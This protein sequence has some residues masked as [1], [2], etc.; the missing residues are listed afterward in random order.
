LLSLAREE[1]LENNLALPWLNDDHLLLE[2]MGGILLHVNISVLAAS[3]MS[4]AQN[5]SGRPDV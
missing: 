3:P 4:I 1:D 5:L 2:M